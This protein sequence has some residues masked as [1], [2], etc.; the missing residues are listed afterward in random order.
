M[1]GGEVKVANYLPGSCFQFQLIFALY[2]GIQAQH[3]QIFPFF[4]E[5]PGIWILIGNLPIFTCWLSTF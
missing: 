3:Y 4:S 5:K 1:D 2:L